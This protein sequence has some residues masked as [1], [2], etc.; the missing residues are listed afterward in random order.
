MLVGRL[1]DEKQIESIQDGRIGYG[2]DLRFYEL[3]KKLNRHICLR[4]LQLVG[5]FAAMYRLTLE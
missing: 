3:S 1:T 4:Y 2:D 5:N